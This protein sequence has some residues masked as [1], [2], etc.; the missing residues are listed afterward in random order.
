MREQQVRQAMVARRKQ[1]E[2]FGTKVAAAVFAVIGVSVVHFSWGT[3]WMLFGAI[4]ALIGVV[5]MF[6]EEGEGS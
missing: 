6:S 4:L 2:E 1:S 5:T 3:W